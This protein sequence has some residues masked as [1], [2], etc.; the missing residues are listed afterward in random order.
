MTTRH[1]YIEKLKN[2]LDE[3]DADIDA[4]EAEM[5]RAK[6]DLKFEMRDQLS[7]IRLKRDNARLKLR[8]LSGAGE[9]AWVDLKAGAEDAWNSLREALEKARSHFG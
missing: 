8:E 2:K 7:A 9:E 3:W 5:S 4:L 6:A 1:E